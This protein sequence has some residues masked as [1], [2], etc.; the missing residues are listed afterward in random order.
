MSDSQTVWSILWNRALK[1]ARPGEP[2]EVSEVVPEVV[3][4]LHVDEKAASRLIQTLLSELA[5]LPDGRQF[6]TLEGGAVV[7]LDGFLKA[8]RDNQA[9]LSVY[10]YEL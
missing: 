1:S 10:P 3:A 7:P 6:F 5:R 2:F 4:A 8:S 9:P